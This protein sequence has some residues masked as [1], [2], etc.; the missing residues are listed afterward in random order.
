MGGGQGSV[1]TPFLLPYYHNDVLLPNIE[2][3]AK[4]SSYSTFGK[5]LHA[6]LA[7][8]NI[9]SGLVLACTTQS[10]Y[11][12]LRSATSSFHDCQS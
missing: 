11:N 6:L 10:T 9:G 5:P 4:K 3:W 2:D 1:G 7:P 12:V 8:V